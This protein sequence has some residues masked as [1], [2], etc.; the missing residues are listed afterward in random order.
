MPAQSP[1]EHETVFSAE[2][3]AP[4][5]P[6]DTFT[7]ASGMIDLEPGDQLVIFTDG[8]ATA[9]ASGKHTTASEI[10]HKL[11]S[12]EVERDGGLNSALRH[13][14]DEAGKNAQRL[15]LTDDLT[16][17]IVRIAER[18]RSEASA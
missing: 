6:A 15:G 3:S 17:V 11:T 16:A 1:S 12:W 5:E 9:L 2:A 13:L 10:E 7:I 4:H 8:V 14:L 18:A